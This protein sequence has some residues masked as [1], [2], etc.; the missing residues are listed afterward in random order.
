MRVRV[1]Q[2]LDDALGPLEALLAESA[3]RVQRHHC[4]K[5]LQFLALLRCELENIVF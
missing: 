5:V 2:V 1:P 4:A 3:A